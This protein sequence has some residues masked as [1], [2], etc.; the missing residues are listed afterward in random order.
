MSRIEDCRCRAIILLE[1][2]DGRAWKITLKIEDICIVS[3]PPAINCLP[4][5]TYYT[6]ILRIIDEIF[7]N[8]ILCG[9]C[10]LV[11][12][13]KYVFEMCFPFAAYIRLVT[14]HS[15]SLEE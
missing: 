7:D 10:I 4:V 12:I 8:Y 15:D 11:L 14:Q 13:D 1:F 2:D 3:A 5:I 6:D 9:I